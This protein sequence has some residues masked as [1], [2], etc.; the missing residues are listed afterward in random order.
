MNSVRPTTTFRACVGAGSL[1]CT[2]SN[3][4]GGAVT[5]N[6]A[7]TISS[8]AFLYGSTGLTVNGALTAG[9]LTVFNNAAGAST[10][11]IN[12]ALTTTSGNI[13]LTSNGTLTIANNLTSASQIL[14]TGTTA[15][16]IQG[17]HQ[18]ASTFTVSNNATLTGNTVLRTT[19][20]TSL[21]SF[22][23]ITGGAYDLSLFST[24]GSITHSAGTITADDVIINAATNATLRT[25]NG[26]TVNGV[27]R[28]GNITLNGV[29][30]ASGSGTPLVLYVRNANFVNSAGASALTTPS[31]R[32]LVYLRTAG[33][34]TIGGLTPYTQV[35]GIVYGDNI[36]AYPTGNY[37]FYNT[38]AAPTLAL[39]VTPTAQTIT[40][41]D[42]IS[43][44]A[45]TLSGLLFGDS[46][47][48][49]PVLATSPGTPGAGFYAAGLTASAGTLVASGYTITYATGA[50]TVNARAITATANTLSHIYGNSVATPTG[51]TI[52]TGSVIGAD[53]LGA[54]TYDLSSVSS[55][56]NVGAYAY[57]MSG[58]TNSNYTIT[59]ANGAYNVTSRAITVTANA[60]LTKQYGNSDPTLAYTITSGSLYSSDA[61]TGSLNRTVG[62][63]VGTY[64]LN[65]G[66]LALNSNYTLT[67]DTAGRSLAITPRPI[68]VRPNALSQVYGSNLTA[69]TGYSLTAGS[70]IGG[71]SLDSPVYSFAGISPASDVG[72]YTYSA[73]GLR[74][75][76]YS[77]SYALGNYAI[78]PKSIT[79]TGVTAANKT[80]DG[81]AVADL[82]GGA[83]S[84]IEAVDTLVSFIP[85]S[86]VLTD[87]LVGTGK[88]VSVSGYSLTGLKSSNYILTQPSGLFASILSIIASPP[89]V[90]A[91]SPNFSMPSTV[92]IQMQY[93]N[94]VPSETITASNS[95]NTIST[96][97]STI[98]DEKSSTRPTPA[99]SFTNKNCDLGSGG[100][101]KSGSGDCSSKR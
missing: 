49:A 63:N 99:F 9:T 52:T 58:L 24:N 18:A 12:N 90:I 39:T 23:S 100:L 45:F 27:A 64:A 38:G 94:S 59:F 95:N 15:I 60:G 35:N 7:R 25:I 16:N 22:Q 10:L 47:T 54:A 1:S 65:N 21:L 101:N 19:G 80:F 11:A 70:I 57:T 33:T 30:T 51:Y 76:N 56:S 55:A 97:D 34:H 87:A 98:I 91:K 82:S 62:E 3:S 93:D 69:P 77:I 37:I 71:D 8:S 13:S 36:S 88:A 17:T 83:L 85:G 31:G 14:M 4:L 28:T 29:I 74:N 73:S 92:R 96:S 86:G 67:I 81:T 48:G 66:N 61:F 40:Y 26:T 42:S 20:S 72:S 78:T 44:A 84:G 6:N 41:G 89:S 79:I 68:T 75:A 32:F 53:N 5:I 43:Q 2:T 50:L 46:F